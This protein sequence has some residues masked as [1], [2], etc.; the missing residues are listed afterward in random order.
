MSESRWPR[1]DEVEIDGRQYRI[2]STRYPPLDLFERHVPPAMLD[3]L[4]ALEARTNPRLRE[5]I[6]DLGRVAPEDRVSGPGASVV[7][8][9]FTHVGWPSRFS[10]GDYGIYYAARALPTAIRET[11]HHRE[12]IARDAGLSAS[13]FSMRVWIGRVRRPLLD[14][15][16]SRWAPLH[17]DA[18]RPEAHREAQAF[19]AAMRAEG[20]WGLCYH[21]VR[22]PGGECLAIFRPPAVSLPTQGAH[23]VY[24]WDG[25][26]ITQ[27]YERSEPLLRFD[28]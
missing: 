18:P 17:D 25:T 12:L 22:D 11:V 27:V 9:A 1:P 7:M 14:I 6:G 16:D 24:V 10:A 4:W 28:E 19:G 5:A 15:R 21:S 8:A 13:E 20:A 2:I 23:L 3:G 26:R